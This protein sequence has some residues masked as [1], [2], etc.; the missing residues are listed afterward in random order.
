MKNLKFRVWNKESNSF[1]VLG[2][3]PDNY[4]FEL[5]FRPKPRVIRRYLGE[6]DGYYDNIVIQQFTGLYDKDGRE[7]YEGDIIYIEFNKKESF[8]RKVVFRYGYFGVERGNILK[9]ALLHQYQNR[10]KILGNIFENT[11]LLT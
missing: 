5:S 11:E 2:S 1:I 3:A 6:L 4:D 8:T 9:P 10:C 7:I